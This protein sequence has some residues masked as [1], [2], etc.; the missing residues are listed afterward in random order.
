MR[1]HGENFGDTMATN[2]WS[3]LRRHALAWSLLIR[4][5]CFTVPNCV[6]GHWNGGAR[7]SSARVIYVCWRTLT[8]TRQ[9]MEQ[10]QNV[11]AIVWTLFCL[12]KSV[13]SK[14][15]I[16]VELTC[17]R[18]QWVAILF[19]FYTIITKQPRQSQIATLVTYINA[20]QHRAL[21]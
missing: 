3:H 20:N 12:F 18:C 14:L 13:V 2:L 17:L 8:G 15:G 4:T 7:E 19:L 6:L 21:K 1:C 5:L 11:Q 16:G 10:L 9:P